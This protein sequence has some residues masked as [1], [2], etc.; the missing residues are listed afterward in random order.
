MGQWTGVDQ[1]CDMILEGDQC[2]VFFLAELW[3]WIL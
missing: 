2:L 3:R 1:A